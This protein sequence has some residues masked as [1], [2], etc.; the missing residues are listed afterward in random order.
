MPN[1]VYVPSRVGEGHFTDFQ[2]PAA[3]ST[4][5]S[6]GWLWNS[7]TG[8]FEPL[9][10]FSA[11]GIGLVAAADAPAARTALGMSAIST[12]ANASLLVNNGTL[13]TTPITGKL[14]ASV[15]ITSARP[16]IAHLLNSPTGSGASAVLNDV[17]VQNNTT[18]ERIFAHGITATLNQGGTPALNRYWMSIDT[19]STP[20][21]SPIFAILSS[22]YI[23]IGSTS[24]TALMDFAAPTT[25]RAQVRFRVGPD[26]TSPADGELWYKT[27]NRLQFRRGS[28]TELIASGT[29]GTG[30]V[31]TAGAS[32]TSTE[33]TM[34]QAAYNACRAFGLLA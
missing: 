22:G 20:W 12:E 1:A 24:A 9:V 19:G 10:T 4:D 29:V 15:F 13:S 5:N 11:F 23:S 26:P 34:L 30:G 7:S 14:P 18:T 31:A 8:K 33:Q 27:A 21:N 28:T 16:G 6:K 32:Y 25:A 3:G 2:S 17:Y